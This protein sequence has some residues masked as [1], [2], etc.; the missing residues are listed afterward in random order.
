[1]TKAKM[2]RVC[3]PQSTVILQLM[4]RDAD[5]VMYADILPILD[6]MNT[7]DILQLM[8]YDV[9]MNE[10]TNHIVPSLAR[11]QINDIIQLIKNGVDVGEL[12]DRIIPSLDKIN[13][14][15]IFRLV[16]HNGVNAY[17]IY[18]YILP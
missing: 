1:M 11:I 18:Y 13:I 17:D 4:D 15:D 7:D 10:L 8:E 14:K 6:Q 3:T 5:P 16:E 9:D 12:T 2:Q